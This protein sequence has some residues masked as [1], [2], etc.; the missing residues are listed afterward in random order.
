MPSR[1]ELPFR[2]NCEGYFLDQKGHILCQDSGKGYLLFP[3]GGIEPGEPAEKAILRETLE[4]TGAVVTNL[5]FLG[6]LKVRWGPTWAKT[7]K[8]RQRYHQYQGDEMH[9]FTGTLVYFDTLQSEE[10]SWGGQKLMPL[11]EAITFLERQPHTPEEQAYRAAQLQY[12]KSLV[13]RNG[14]W[15]V[16][17]NS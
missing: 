16:H 7:E 14:V 15:D 2:D 8:Q 9:F 10:D 12:L 1:S 4:E 17:N 6:M 13:K 5:V 3:G 11:Q